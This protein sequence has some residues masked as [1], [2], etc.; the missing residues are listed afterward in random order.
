[1]KTQHFFE[2]FT[3]LYSLSKTIRFELKPIGKTLENIKK[4]GLI[5]RDEQRLDDYE[6]LKKVIDEYHEDF[7]ANI[8]SSFS[9]SEEILQ[10]YIQNLSESEARAKIEKT[11]RDTLA[12]AFSE[13][14]RYKSIFKKE[15]VKKDIP[16]WCPAYK[17]LCKKFDNFTTSLVPFHENRKNLYT[18]NEITASIPYRIVHVNLPKFIQNI[19]ALCELQKKMGADLYLEMMENL[20]NVWPSFVKTPDDLCNLKTYNHLMV[21]SSISEYNRFVGGYSTEDGTKHQGINEWI[22]IYRQRNKEMRLPGLVFLHKQIL[23]KVDSSSFISD[24][25]END[26]QVFC[27]LRQFRKLFWN[28]V[29]SKEDD[30]ASLKDLFCGL[31]GYDPEAIYV[32]DAHLATISKNIF[33]RWNYIS[34]AIRRKTEVLM[35]R[36]KESVERYA[37]KISK[38][39]KKRQ[40]Y[41]LAE[42]DDLL[43]HYS[44]ESL[45]AGFSLLSYFTS[46]GG[47]KY[48]VS[49]GEV[50]LYEEGSNIWDEV[51]IAF[52]DLQVILDKDFTEKKLGKDEEAVSVIKKA[53]DSALRLRKFF[54]LL[55]GTGAEI[56]RDSSF[57]ALYTDRMDKLKGLL[58][59]YDKVRNYLTKKPYSI[60]KFKL[61]FDNPSLLSGWDKNK[62]LNNL[63]VIFRQNGYYYLGIM[64]PK[65]KN[66]FKTLPKLGA[67]EMFYEK[68]EYKQIAEPM[69]MLPKVFFPKKTKPAFAPD[70]SVVDIYNKKTFKT[71]QKGFNK[72]D[73]YRLIDFYKEALTV[74]EWKLFNFSFSPTEQYRNIGEFFDEVREQAYKVSMVNVPA[75]YIDEAVENGKLYLFQIYN[76]DFSPYSKGIPNLHTLYWKALF[77]EQNQSRVYKLCGGGELFYRKASLHMQDTTV[78][79]KGI[80]IHKKNLNKKG[81]TSLFNYD[82]VKD[83][84]FTEDKFFFHVPISINYKNKKITNVN[85]MVRDYIAQN[86]DLQ[87]IGIDRGERNLLYISRIDTRGNLLEQF[88]LNVIE[89][90]KGD[91]RTD[92]QKI[93]GDREQERLRRRQE[94]KSIE[95]IKD[96]KDGYMSQVVHKICNMVVEHKA[97]VVLENLNLS[98]MKG[99]KKV[100][101]S[102][103]EKFERML[104]DKLNYLVVDKKNLSNE[105]GGLYAAYQLTNP[106]F[107]FEELHRYPQSG[108]LFF[109]DPWNTSLTDPSTGFVN[110][111]GRI[112]YTNVG[113]AR[114]F[115][116][117][118]NAIRYDGKGNILFDLDLSRFDVRVE[119]QRKLWTLTTFGSRIAKSKKSGKWMV[120]RIENLS[121]CFLE[122]FEQFNIGYRVEKDL[123]K[124][125]L[126][127]DRKEFYVRLIYLFNL[128]MQIR[129]SDGEE[130]YILS[131]AL[132]EKNLQF[133]SRLIEAK[134]LP[135]DADANGAYNVA[136]K[137][138]MVVQ[139]I[140][141]GD[142]ESI[143]R[144]GRAQWLRYVQEGIVE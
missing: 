75:S 111:L 80:S 33:D 126:S 81:E 2:D 87:I 105:P 88:S 38:Q 116:D 109:V 1:M 32:S 119:T 95:S 77:S 4:N 8:L 91:L 98:F 114:K 121:L 11:M 137:G 41:S 58:K 142:H 115:F 74:H 107:S 54:D 23:A 22:N 46:L 20:R 24:T 53:L 16:V 96:L 55:S 134:D 66:L 129:N 60:E 21:Q 120:E 79:P 106:L 5:R 138:L 43:A 59:M 118:F 108:I 65:G 47:Q 37:E 89:S 42:L 136:R 49:D 84:R 13:D 102:V 71:G 93:L 141:R 10:S 76:K 86:D 62:E 92:Y 67:E 104:V 27:V 50:I 122:L 78:H 73:L 103:Y 51:L 64:T 125:I 26:D 61:H 40:S 128:M 68:M 101:K 133:D 57:Y 17:S 132:N 18:S 44:E 39:I 29:S 15:L 30:A 12:K 72:K 14:E 117:R 34:D 112:N 45:P 6:K 31:S 100:E 123:K 90:D 99:R 69:L 144:I 97:I 28:T 94:W 63:S 56:R 127:Q 19:E 35:P 36:K 131:P 140:K 113:D 130:D 124:A 139:R 48:L 70:Q 25:L 82:L 52:R 135:V 83:K 143:H 9:F 7:I 85:Q 110:L 3:S